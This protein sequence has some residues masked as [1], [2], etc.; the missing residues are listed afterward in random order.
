MED[1]KI[2]DLFF[3]RSEKAI[4]E[5][6]IKYGAYCNAIAFNILASSEDAEE[7]VSDSYMKLWSAIPPQRP[8]SLKSFLG[9]IT[10]NLALDRWDRLSAEKRGGGEL[11]LALEELSECIAAERGVEQELDR[12]GLARVI[13]GFLGELSPG[14]R[15]VFV[16]R[17]W[18]LE[19]IKDIA[20]NTGS[21]ESSVKT[22]LHRSRTA[23]KEKLEKEGFSI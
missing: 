2:V 17:Y 14:P 18:Y 8:D 15:Q 10:R 11:P 21:S 16:R 19:S 23:L 1:R 9:R 12:A 22:S 7:C 3:E 13:N 20:E 5:T 6:A 4:A